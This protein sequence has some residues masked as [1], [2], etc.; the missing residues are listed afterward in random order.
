LNSR[1]PKELESSGMRDMLLAWSTA[2]RAQ[3]T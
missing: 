1:A 2:R 3:L